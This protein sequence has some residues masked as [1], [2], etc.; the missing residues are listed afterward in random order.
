[1]KIKIQKKKSETI[2]ESLGITKERAEELRKKVN[3]IAEVNDQAT[4]VMQ[5]MAHISKNNSEF[6]LSCFVVG[7]LYGERRAR[8]IITFSQINEKARPS[9]LS[10]FLQGFAQGLILMGII[11]LVVALLRLIF[12]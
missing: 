1:M 8:P 2:Y 4:T 11:M 3:T 7:S 12:G 10:L 6:A 9:T 5:K